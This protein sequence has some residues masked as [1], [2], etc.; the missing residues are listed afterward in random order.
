[1]LPN[2]LMTSFRSSWSFL[3]GVRHT[4]DV[5]GRGNEV[6]DVDDGEPLVFIFDC[7]LELFAV[8]SRVGT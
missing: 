6:E 7:K 4:E 2:L 1:M 3:R 8:V 5:I